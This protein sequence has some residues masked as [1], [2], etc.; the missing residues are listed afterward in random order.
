MKATNSIANQL[1]KAINECKP[2]LEKMFDGRQLSRNQA[3]AISESQKDLGGKSQQDMAL[4]LGG[5]KGA[6]GWDELVKERIEA[7]K[8]LD[9]LSKFIVTELLGNGT[10]AESSASMGYAIDNLSKA[11]NAILEFDE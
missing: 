6:R 7:Y 2:S 10:I 4:A 11:I 3:K 8:K 1:I 5:R 9:P